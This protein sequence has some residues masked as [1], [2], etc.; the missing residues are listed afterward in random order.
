MLHMMNIGSLNITRGFNLFKARMFDN[1]ITHK[2]G[3]AT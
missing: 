1:S 2:K 3:K